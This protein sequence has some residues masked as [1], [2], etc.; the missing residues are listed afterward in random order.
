MDIA[1][2]DDP[3]QSTLTKCCDGK[4]NDFLPNKSHSPEK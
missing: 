1:T 4:H 2:A 3:M